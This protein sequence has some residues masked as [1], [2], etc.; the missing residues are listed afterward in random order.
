VK[1]SQELRIRRATPD[2][3]EAL[4]VIE[5]ASFSMPWPKEVLLHDLT[6]E[7]GQCYWVVVVHHEVVAYIGGWIIG[8]DFHIGSLATAP[9]YR[10]RGIA[11]LLMLCALQYAARQGAEQAFLEHRVSNYPAA[12]LYKELGFRRLRIRRGYYTDKGEDAV[13]LALSGLQSEATRLR[14]EQEL[15][16]WLRDHLYDVR[17]TDLECE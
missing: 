1:A 7:R 6:G 2:D 8:P 12:V 4:L 17:L 16:I 10:R 15:D 5:E 11:K 13:E 9:G 3:L 14:L